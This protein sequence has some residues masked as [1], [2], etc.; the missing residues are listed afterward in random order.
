MIEN[1]NHV[2]SLAGVAPGVK[3]AIIQ[4]YE[5]AQQTLDRESY[6][7]EYSPDYPDESWPEAYNALRVVST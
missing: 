2:C 6:A 5:M 4:L 1:Q 7:P 3:H